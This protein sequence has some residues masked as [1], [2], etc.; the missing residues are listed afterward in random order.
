QIHTH[1]SS[2]NVHS[3]DCDLPLFIPLCHRLTSYSV[4]CH[5]EWSALCEWEGLISVCSTQEKAKR[6]AQW[7]SRKGRQNI[8]VYEISTG[9]L[10]WAKL[11]LTSTTKINA[12]VNYEYNVPVYFIKASELISVLGLRG[13]IKLAAEN[14]ACEEW[15]APE[16]I[17][18][19]MICA[20]YPCS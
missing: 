11:D 18:V 6:E 1:T 12:F 15:F 20:R 17:P 2:I 13:R 9:D 14:G 7:R 5:L 4:K 19:D 3:W 10:R 8:A 16:W